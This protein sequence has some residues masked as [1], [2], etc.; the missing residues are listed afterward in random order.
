MPVD[1]E[2]GRQAK[3]RVRLWTTWV[4]ALSVPRATCHITHS[5]GR[6][7]PHTTRQLRLRSACA[8]LSGQTCQPL[9]PARP[10]APLPS[11]PGPV[12]QAAD[13]FASNSCAVTGWYL[14]CI[15][16]IANPRTPQG[17]DPF[18]CDPLCRR[19]ALHLAAHRGHVAA[20][21][22][23]TGQL[24]TAELCRWLGGK[25][26]TRGPVRKAGGGGKGIA[27]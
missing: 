24:G 3:K 1:C 16:V 5:P 18:A 26:V 4:W 13:P 19:T 7:A 12:P 15:T 25:G 8:W 14:D 10:P 17:A 11:P 27:A 9:C 21:E 6:G 22:A 2:A 20:A 23:L